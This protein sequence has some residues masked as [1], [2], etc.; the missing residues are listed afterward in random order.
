[1]KSL[2]SDSNVRALIKAFDLDEPKL[3]NILIDDYCF[4]NGSIVIKSAK[5]LDDKMNFIRF[6]QL[7]K[8][9]CLINECNVVFNARKQDTSKAD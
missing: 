1:M 4:E 2:L 7:D 3:Y 5:V 6:A 9:V 8:L